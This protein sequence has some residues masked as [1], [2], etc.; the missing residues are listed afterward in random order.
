M[1]G[2]ITCGRQKE[3]KILLKPNG[4]KEKGPSHTDWGKFKRRGGSGT[5]NER[6]PCHKKKG[7]GKVGLDRI[8]TL[9]PY[10]PGNRINQN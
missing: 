8:P 4:K 1:R 9:K 6:E 7:G 5:A 2:K 3:K 10:Y